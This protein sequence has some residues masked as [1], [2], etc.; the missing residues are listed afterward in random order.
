M[1][2]NRK[3]LHPDK[4]YIKKLENPAIQT[5]KTNTIENENVCYRHGINVVIVSKLDPIASARVTSVK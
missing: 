1:Y 2:Q 5:R 3:F 4:K